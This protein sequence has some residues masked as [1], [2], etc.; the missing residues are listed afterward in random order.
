MKTVKQGTGRW[1]IALGL[2][3]LAIPAIAGEGVSFVTPE[4]GAEVSSPIQVEMAVTGMDIEPAG[5]MKEGTGHHH[6]LIDAGPITEGEVVPTDDTHIHFGGGQ[7]SYE[8]SLPPG[9]YTLTLQFADGAHLSYG[10]DWSSTI[11]VNVVE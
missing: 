10:P 7:T 6:L 4:D 9:E 11:T 2:A 8:L 1:L 3:M 5:T